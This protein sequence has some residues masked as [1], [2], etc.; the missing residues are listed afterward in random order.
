MDLEVKEEGQG[1]V[2]IESVTPA[3][4][5]PYLIEGS[6]PISLIGRHFKGIFLEFPAEGFSAWFSRFLPDQPLVLQA[7]GSGSVLE[8]RIA[9]RHRIRGKWETIEEAG[10]PPQY[11]QM[12]FTPH[13]ATRAIF[14]QPVEYQTF[15]VHF[16][17]PYLEKFGLDYAMMDRFIAKVHTRQPAELAP[18]PYKCSLEML[19][20]VRMILNSKHSAPGRQR[21]LRHHIA[22]L[23]TAALEVVAWFEGVP[24][25]LTQSDREALHRIREILDKADVD[26]YPGNDELLM[27]VFPHLN[28]WKLNYGFKQLFATNPQDYFLRRRF[29]EAQQLLAKGKRVSDVAIEVG[30][31]SA[32]TFIK[33]FRKRFGVTP[34]QWKMRH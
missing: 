14:E 2:R 6:R 20:I 18:H 27:R 31:E 12:A 32:T 16:E 26:Q 17:L 19:H 9:W 15:D 34:K 22:A 21:Q 4:L 24:M 28:T 7:Q 25:P 8:L 11:F 3:I 30:Y 13:V 29:S 33:E 23:L 5:Q 1:T 10:M